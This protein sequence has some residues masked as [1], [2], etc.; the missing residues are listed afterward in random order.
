MTARGVDWSLRLGTHGQL[1]EG[2]EDVAQSVR[3]ILGTPMGSDPMRPLFGSE[4]FRHLDSPRDRA[5]PFLIRDA[6]RALARWEPRL[7]LSR[8]GVEFPSI[9]SVR[10]MVYGRLKEDPEA[11]A[12]LVASFDLGTSSPLPVR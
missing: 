1:A 3:L 5:V 10:L 7:A 8:I 12:G 6:A 11:Q 4:I 9:S 2:L